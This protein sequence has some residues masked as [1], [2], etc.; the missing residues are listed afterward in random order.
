MHTTGKKL[1]NLHLV[2]EDLALAR[3]RLGDE[4]V[5][6]DVE[7]ILADVLELG[8]DLLAVFADDSDVLVRALGLLLLLDAGN[9]TPRSTTG[10]DYV[11]VGHGQ[12]VTLVNGKFAADLRSLR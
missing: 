1:A 11:L 2:V 9:D 12:Q 6:E 4:A 10:A 3:L 7:D 8:L 5:I